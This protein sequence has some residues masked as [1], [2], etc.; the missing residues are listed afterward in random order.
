MKN[1]VLNNYENAR[2]TLHEIRSL[3]PTQNQV[4]T[5]KTGIID[6]FN[7]LQGIK[8]KSQNDLLAHLD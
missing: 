2:A 5:I 7:K 8:K 1:L 3:N 6:I 4:M